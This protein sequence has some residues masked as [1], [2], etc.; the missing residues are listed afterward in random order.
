[1]ETVDI[2]RTI[3]T[4]FG[5]VGVPD[6]AYFRRSEWLD[7]SCLKLVLSHLMD[8]DRDDQGQSRIGGV[9]PLCATLH[10]EAMK[11]QTI[12]TSPFDSSN[13]LVLIPVFLDGH[14]AGAVLDY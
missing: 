1:M 7:D 3:D 13:R 8:Q 12:E 5:A 10:D 4:K 6:L 2:E 14:W 9:N 11:L